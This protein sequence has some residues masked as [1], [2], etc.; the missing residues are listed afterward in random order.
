MNG[1]IKNGQGPDPGRDG[2]GVVCAYLPLPPPTE[3]VAPAEPVDP[4]VPDMPEPCGI[5][6]PDIPLWPP[7]EPIELLPG[8]EPIMLLPALLPVVPGVA[9]PAGLVD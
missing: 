9:V 2:L 1:G 8:V 4:A 5:A 6:V 3:P 7:C